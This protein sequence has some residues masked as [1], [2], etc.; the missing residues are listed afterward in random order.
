[1]R[2]A[3]PYWNDEH[4]IR[5]L[6]RVW[7]AGRH[8]VLVRYCD[9]LVVMCATRQQAEAALGRLRLVLGGMGL[10]LK[11]AKTRIRAPDRG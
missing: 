11:E 9:D 7:D 8:G 3:G 4:E 1:M 6:D 5:R 10:E 2:S